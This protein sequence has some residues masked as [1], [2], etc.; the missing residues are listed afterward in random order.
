MYFSKNRSLILII[1]LCISIFTFKW[2]LSS[3]FYNEDI[4]TKILYESKIDGDGAFY[5]PFI[6]FLSSLNFS[7]SFDPFTNN[8]KNLPIPYGSIFIQS[9][10]YKFL[11][12]I[13]FIIIEILAVFLFLYFFYKIYNFYFSEEISVFFSLLLFSIPF[14]LNILRLNQVS[15]LNILSSD[16]FSFRTHR[17]VFSH[18]IFYCFIYVIF[19]IDYSNNFNKKYFIILGVLSGLSFAGFYYHFVI[20]YIFIFFY[21]I[22]KFNYRLLNFIYKNLSIFLYLIFFFFVIT[23]FF[24]FSTFLT[25]KDYLLRNGLFSLNFEKKYIL[26]KYYIYQYTSTKFFFLLLT[27]FII[28]YFL[29]KNKKKNLLIIFFIFFL[30]SIFAPLIFILFSN[31]SGILYHFNNSV[32][33]CYFFLI[34]NSFL[35]AF[36]FLFEK[37]KKNYVTYILIFFLTLIIYL[38]IFQTQFLKYNNYNERVSRIEFDNVLKIYKINRSKDKKLNNSVLTFDNYLMIWLIFNEVDYLNINNQLFS[39]KTD[40]V[41][42]NDLI[43]NF[44]FLGLTEGSFVKF[45]ENK[46]EN[47]RVINYN[48]ADFFRSKYSANSLSTY[49]DSKD[50]DPNI[51][52][53]ILRSSPILSQQIAIPNNELDRLKKK[54]NIININADNFLIPEFIILN[55]NNYIYENIS[56]NIKNYTIL[57]NG[58]FYVLYKQSKK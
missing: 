13:G 43:K 51:K 8:L 46:N 37:F 33:V 29:R 40:L 10:F 45:L 56:K 53:L 39:T 9:I 17:P 24:I 55:K 11:G 27:S 21:L 3:L 30:S 58:N 35:L 44:K 41:I 32:V 15:Y 6:K 22:Y 36:N 31:K 1:C 19:L 23:S 47:W 54:F 57:Y 7:N 49:N 34:F 42:E 48:V 16:I 26:I 38:N 25:E 28:I 52:D 2:S 20:E 5:F 4:F 18:L 12:F 14:F 50:F